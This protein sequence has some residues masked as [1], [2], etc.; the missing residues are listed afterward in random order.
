V[1]AADEEPA[2]PAP[3]KPR[4]SAGPSLDT[5]PAQPEDREAI[6]TLL[7]RSLGDDGDPRYSELFAWKHDTNRFGPSPMWVA[8]DGGRVVAFRA[9]MRWEFVRGG[10]VLRAVRAVDT[11]TDPDY[12][13]R[14]LFR[15]LTMHGLESVEAEGVDFVFNT[16]NDQ[17]RPGYLKMGW[18]EVG[19]LPAAVRFTGPTGALRAVRSRVPAD[20]WSTELDVGVPVLDWLVSGGPGGRLAAPTDVRE[21]CTNVDDGF[22]AWRFGTPLLGYRVVDDGDSGVIV[23]A[24]MRGASKELAVV[25]EFGAPTDTQRLGAQVAK[26]A[27]CSY[28]IRIGRPSLATGYVALPGGGPILTWRS[29]NDEGL[30][31]LPNWRLTLGDIELF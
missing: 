12:Q 20:R 19:R 22:L 11:A 15:S 26:D 30:P 24:R 23:R 4:P 13:G 25:A 7:Q 14:G 3:A 9:L 21:I 5:R 6:I 27:G 8:T 28:A 16:P 31:P 10:K 1:P 2:A 17:S 29:V 18:R